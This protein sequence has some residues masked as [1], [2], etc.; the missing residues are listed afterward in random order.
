MSSKDGMWSL[1]D[2]SSKGAKFKFKF[3]YFSQLVWPRMESVEKDSS[4]VRLLLL[5]SAWFS[6]KSV[7]VE[8]ER[9]IVENLRLGR[10]SVCVVK[11][12]KLRS[13]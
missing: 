8:L 12:R 5:Q 11:S 7:I 4:K 2:R 9:K 1:G 13:M 10:V 6:F 3:K